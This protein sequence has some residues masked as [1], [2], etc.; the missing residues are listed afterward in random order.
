MSRPHL[1]VT[2]AAGELAVLFINEVGSHFKLRL[3]DTRPMELPVEGA[4]SIHLDIRDIDS[5]RAACEGID[6]VLHLAADPSP[7]A[8]FLLIAAYEHSRHP[9]T[10]S[11]QRWRLVANGWYLQAAHKPLRVTR[12]MSSCQ[13]QPRPDP[14]IC[15]GSRKHLE[16]RLPLTTLKRMP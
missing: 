2:G 15:M 10:C 7:T 1:L 8:D 13:S 9:S 5:C 16:R 3:A 11:P 12:S 6:L 14:E 4:Q